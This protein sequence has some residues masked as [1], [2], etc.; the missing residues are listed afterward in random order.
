MLTT[1]RHNIKITICQQRNG[2]CQCVNEHNSEKFNQIN[3]NDTRSTQLYQ[4]KAS[5]RSY[6]SFCDLSFP[7]IQLK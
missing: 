3:S 4:Y 7:K 2:W 6:T 1:F 5:T